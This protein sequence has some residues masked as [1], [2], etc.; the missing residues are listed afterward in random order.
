MRVHNVTQRISYGVR[1]LDYQGLT[2]D[3]LQPIRLGIADRLTCWALDGWL[4][5]L[6]LFSGDTTTGCGVGVGQPLQVV[7]GALDRGS[8]PPGRAL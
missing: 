2:K 8:S 5:V 7:V 1:L 3:Q 6:G 4:A